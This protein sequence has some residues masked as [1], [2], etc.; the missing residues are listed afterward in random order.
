MTKLL[1]AIAL[2]ALLSSSCRTHTDE[3]KP[4][5]FSSNIGVV[6][7]KSRKICLSIHNSSLSAG[8]KVRV[9][10]LASPQAGPEEAIVIGTDDTCSNSAGSDANLTGYQIHF[11]K[12]DSVA[13]PAIGIIGVSGAFRKKGDLLA[14]DLDGDGKEEYFRSCTSAEGV[15]FSIWSEQPL[16]GTAR[17]TQYYYLGYD[18]E[19]TCTPK[20]MELKETE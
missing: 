6:A 19:P 2:A 10:R 20:E 12:S 1:T 15:H 4:W 3:Q 11:E 5:S 18:V 9:L 13:A 17:W 8:R 7:P 14:A 16:L